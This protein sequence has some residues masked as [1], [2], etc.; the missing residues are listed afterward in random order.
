MYYDEDFYC[1][2]SEFDQQVENFKTSLANAV[3]DEFKTEMERLRKE[4]AELQDIKKRFSEITSEH[5]AKLNELNREK[6]QIALK[7]KNARLD[8]LLS[9]NKLDG[10]LVGYDMNK[11]EKCGKCDSLR[12]IQY[13]TPSGRPATEECDC[14]RNIY[15]YFP[16]EIECYRFVQSRK[17]WGGNYPDITRYFSRESD[18][19]YDEYNKTTNVYNGK[20]FEEVQRYGIVFLDKEVCQKYCDWLT[21]KERAKEAAADE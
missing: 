9:E 10:W 16:K 4:N 11:A 15:S 8:E 2:P 19:D 13:T 6:S 20:P 14:N 18:R 7:L 5:Q 12:R 21:E 1:E 17:S 3:K